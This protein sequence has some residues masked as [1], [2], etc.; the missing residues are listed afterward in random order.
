MSSPIHRRQFLRAAAAL[1]VGLAAFPAVLRSGALGSDK[2]LNVAGIGVGGKGAIDIGYCAGENVVALCDV[3]DANA[4]ESYKRF[5]QA[6][7]YKDYRKMLDEEGARIDAVTVSTPDHHHAPAAL[8][9]MRLGKH[10]YCQKPLTHSVAEARRMADA[11]RAAKVT[12]QMGNQGFSHPRTRRL[13][14]LIQAGVLGTVH[15]VHVWTDRPI[16]PQGVDRP[17]DSP[18]VPDTLA[19]DLWLG[20]A[21]QRPYNPAYVPFKWRGFWDFG[22]GALGDMGCHN[23]GL[24][25]WALDLRDPLTVE[26]VSSPVNAETAPTRSMITYEFGA[27][28][29]RKATRLVWYD[30]G[31]KPSRHLVKAQELG[32]NGVILIGDKDTLYVPSY[33]GG[34]GFLSG[35]RMDDFK[36]VPMRLP[37]RPEG[38]DND[39]AHHLEWIDACKGGPPPSSSF[40]E[41]SGPFTEMV[42]LGN[43][44]LRAG[45]KV[46][47][48]AKALRVKN[49]AASDAR[50][51]STYRKGWEIA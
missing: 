49:D 41:R 36:E 37:R 27:L 16:W 26:A 11:A 25:F 20:P 14:E 7:R 51:H 18:A 22:T 45:G 5:P 48:D 35:A 1:P 39:L 47:W 21:P 31:L 3:D 12:T 8:L 30:G 29:D 15:E 42:L 28:G 44:A 46:E 10:V 13:V 43:V 6:K 2:K 24:P 40:P 32:A 4:A 34:G 23:M 9:A 17:A 50:I 38:E 19:W 33:W